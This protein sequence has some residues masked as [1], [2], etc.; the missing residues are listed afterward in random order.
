[1]GRIF[2]SYRRADSQGWAGRL[3]QALA[4][5][6]GELALFFDIDSIAPG[7]DFAE[8]I[9]GAVSRSQVML[10][11]IG[12]RWLS[13]SLD[14]GS[15]RLD[16]PRDYVRLEVAAGL[17]RGLQLV[18]VLLGGAVMPRAEELPRPI[19]GLAGRQA[20]ELSDTRWDYDCAR[21]IEAMEGAGLERRAAAAGAEDAATIAVGEGIVLDHARAADI[22]GIKGQGARLPAGSRIEVARGAVLR[23]SRVQD[24][25]GIKSTG[26][27]PDE[28]R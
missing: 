24:I 14:G 22:A 18:P 1:V 8:A 11:L 3:G 15:R 4:G 5:A 23:E 17:V 10:V 13:A 27:A 26:S 20:L 6:F 25:V 16:D 21:L 2:V 12:P 7:E 9:H 28:G 19:R